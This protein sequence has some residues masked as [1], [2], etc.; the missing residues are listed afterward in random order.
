MRSLHNPQYLVL[1]RHSRENG[2]PEGVVMIVL[3]CME[4]ACLFHTSDS[5][6]KVSICET[7][8]SDN[9]DKIFFRN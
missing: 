2:N 8:R 4:Q 3:S 6:A 5:Y 1:C 9:R 7:K